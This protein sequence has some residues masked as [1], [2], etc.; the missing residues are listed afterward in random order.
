[1][2]NPGFF[3]K[4]SYELLEIPATIPPVR[5]AAGI[6][7]GATGDLVGLVS[8]PVRVQ[9]CL[10]LERSGLWIPFLVSSWMR[11]AGFLPVQQPTGP[12]LRGFS[13][14]GF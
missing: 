8:D 2:V 1:M 3:Q 14:R 4:F 10:L 13:G 7:S 5:T 11:R 6:V 12:F 9:F